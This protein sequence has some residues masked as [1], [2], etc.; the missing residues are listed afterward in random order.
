MRLD[1]DLAVVAEAVDQ[2]E[3]IVRS[4]FQGDRLRRLEIVV[5]GDRERYFVA[6]GQGP[7]Q[8]DIQEE[9]LE[10]LEGQRDPAETAAPREAEA[11][12]RQVV[13]ESAKGTFNSAL[14]SAPVTSE[15]C[16]SR[17]SGKYSRTLTG[18]VED[19][20]PPP[21]LSLPSLLSPGFPSAF[22]SNWAS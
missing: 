21:P 13:I 10:D 22:L 18:G 12:I 15:G 8:V 19:A 1:L 17:V 11:D 3:S 7:R 6:L 4:Q 2:F 16:H 5:D 20:P 14:P 9:V